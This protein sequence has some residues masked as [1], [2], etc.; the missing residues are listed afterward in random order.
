MKLEPKLTQFIAEIE[1]AKEILIIAAKPIDYDCI[2]TSLAVKSWIMDNYGKDPKAV[3]FQSMP[4]MYRKIRGIEKLEVVEELDFSLFDLILL[5][6]GNSFSRFF[7]KN[8]KSAMS[9]IE[10]DEVVFCIDHHVEDDISKRIPER[11]FRMDASSTAEVFYREILTKIDSKISREVCE[12]LAIALLGDTQNFNVSI[13][14]KTFE[15]AAFLRKNILDFEALIDFV[16][17]YPKEH[18]EFMNFLISKT[19]FFPEAKTTIVTIDLQVLVEIESKFGQDWESQRLDMAYKDL[20][21]RSIDDYIFGIILIERKN[22]AVIANWRC[23]GFNKKISI[24]EILKKIR[25]GGGGHLNAGSAR[26]ENSDIHLVEKHL[27]EN[28]QSSL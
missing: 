1:S 4:N 26:A 19:K 9:Q 7:G 16:G 25:F 17:S 27:L 8:I 20:F 3:V 23:S 28:I 12:M 22:S 2:G 6:D 15:F 14:P 18:F 11:T 5:I 24:L 13:Y 21:L 10:K